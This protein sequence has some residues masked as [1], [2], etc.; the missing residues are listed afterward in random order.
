MVNDDTYSIKIDES[1]IEKTELDGNGLA[2]TSYNVKLPDFQSSKNKVE[3]GKYLMT[4][5]ED[6]YPLV[7]V[8]VRNLFTYHK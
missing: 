6:R 8:I 7:L 5:E 2:L 4:F 3:I 1:M